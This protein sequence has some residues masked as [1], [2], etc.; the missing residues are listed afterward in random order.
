ML[1]RLAVSAM[2]AVLGAA[3]GAPATE[4][5]LAT[6]LTEE[7][8]MQQ[9]TELGTPGPA[10]ARLTSLVG[11]WTVKCEAFTAPDAPPTISEGRA[12]CSLELGG[13]FVMQQFES[14]FPGMPFHGVSY[15]GYDNLSQ[16]YQNFWIDSMATGMMPI[17]SGTA[18]ATGTVLTLRRAFVD[19][20]M[21]QPAFSREVLTIHGP[22]HH[23]FEWH[24]GPTAGGEG[25]MMRL[26]YTRAK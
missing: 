6:A 2:L 15:L 18:D 23:T 19:P 26:D 21:R 11:N 22:D 8:M 5:A 17:S 10:H 20:M 9:M 12:T 7:Q 4:P 24:Q 1:R 13:R 16:T 3:C 14:D 25:L